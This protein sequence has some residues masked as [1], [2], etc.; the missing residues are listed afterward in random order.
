MGWEA[1]HDEDGTKEWRKLKPKERKAGAGDLDPS[2]S[3]AGAETEASL[4]LFGASC[5]QRLFLVWYR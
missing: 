3:E 4:R 1:V 5:I 2:T